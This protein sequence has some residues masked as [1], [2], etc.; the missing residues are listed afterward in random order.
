MPKLLRRFLRGFLGI[1]TAS[2]PSP[3]FSPVFPRFTNSS[4]RPSSKS[5]PP[6]NLPGSP[7]SPSGL[8]WPSLAQVCRESGLFRAPRKSVK[9]VLEITFRLT[10]DNAEQQNKS[11]M[12]EF[13]A[14]SGRS[15]GSAFAPS[16]LWFSDQSGRATHLQFGK[17]SGGQVRI[18]ILSC[19]VLLNVFYLK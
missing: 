6:G 12:V 1:L 3:T 14:L 5:P 18:V 15:L 9:G 19:P 11:L 17:K 13:Q 4:A 2:L 7:L 8:P 10:Q 16:V